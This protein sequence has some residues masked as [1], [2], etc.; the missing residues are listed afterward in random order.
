MDE[1]KEKRDIFIEG[2]TRIA[3][4]MF[5]KDDVDTAFYKGFKESDAGRFIDILRMELVFP[6]DLPREYQIKFE[7]K[8]NRAVDYYQKSI[9]NN[10]DEE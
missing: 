5:T 4:I 3:S 1:N 10:N 6:D 9:K 8:F 2:A 7:H